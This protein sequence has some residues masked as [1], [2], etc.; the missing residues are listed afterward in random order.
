MD[1]KDGNVIFD[2]SSGGVEQNTPE[3][4]VGDQVAPQPE[5]APAEVPAEPLQPPPPPPP[6]GPPKK[7]IIIGERGSRPGFKLT[8]Q[9]F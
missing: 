4:P 2:N 1:A 3:Q 9:R 6:A 5:G 7:F 8:H